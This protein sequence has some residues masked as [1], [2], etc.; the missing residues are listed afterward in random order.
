MG[1][2]IN[3]L[4]ITRYKNLYYYYWPSPPDITNAIY[5]THTR[6]DQGH[7]FY[8]ETHSHKSI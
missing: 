3:W 8:I 4:E 7:V 2:L 1:V 6:L 5:I